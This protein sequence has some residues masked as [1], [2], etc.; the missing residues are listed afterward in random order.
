MA[1][2]GYQLQV[3]CLLSLCKTCSANLLNA[4]LVGS[5]RWIPILGQLH[6]QDHRHVLLI[7]S[8]LS[9]LLGFLSAVSYDD[10]LSASHVQNTS[11]IWKT[12]CSSQVCSFYC[13]LTYLLGVMHAQLVTGMT[14]VQTHQLVIHTFKRSRRRRCLWRPYQLTLGSSVSCP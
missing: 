12:F 8:G 9:L 11:W 7:L 10:I 4:C 5:V 6:Q 2:G 1:P 14:W 13:H 3:C